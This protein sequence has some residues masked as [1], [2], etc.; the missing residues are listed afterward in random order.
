MNAYHY[1]WVTKGL[2]EWDTIIEI[3]KDAGAKW[4]FSCVPLE[5]RIK[6]SV[7]SFK[8]KLLWQCRPR[9]IFV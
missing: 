5:I 9:F 3:A 7:I 8:L 1:Q 4:Q 6:G 2:L